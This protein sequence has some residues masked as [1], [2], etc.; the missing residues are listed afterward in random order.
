MSLEFDGEII[1][2]DVTTIP[3]FVVD[4]YTVTVE[5]QD[6]YRVVMKVWTMGSDLT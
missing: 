6:E 1:V 5:I 3:V 2:R 4:D